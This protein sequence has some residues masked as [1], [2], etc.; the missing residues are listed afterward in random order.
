MRIFDVLQFF[1]FLPQV[2]RSLIVS[3]KLVYVCELFHELLNDLK[4]SIL[5]SRESSKY[6][7]SFMKV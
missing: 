2:K 3:N 6:C 1:F 4:L 5:E 7:A